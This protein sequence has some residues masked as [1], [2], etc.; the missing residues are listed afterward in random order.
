MRKWIIILALFIFIPGCGDTAPKDAVVSGPPDS[1]FALAAPGGGI[2]IVRPILFTVKDA[3]GRSIP[4]V[5]LEIIVNNGELVDIHDN[6]IALNPPQNDIWVTRT[7]DEGALTVA[8]RVTLIPCNGSTKPITFAAS[9]SASTG[10]TND[11]VKLTWTTA[12]AAP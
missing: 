1:T 11:T 5:E 2:R 4:D 3:Q 12:C 8:V 7:D 9:V 6:I 10:F